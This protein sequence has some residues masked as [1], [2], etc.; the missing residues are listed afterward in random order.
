MGQSSSCTYSIGD[1][2]VCQLAASG[3]VDHSWQAS[4]TKTMFLCLFAL[5]IRRKKSRSWPDENKPSLRQGCRCWLASLSKPLLAICRKR[6]NWAKESQSNGI[7]WRT[8][9][10][11]NTGLKE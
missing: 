10:P 6:R 7:A 11:C 8:L 3:H 4:S 2:Q 5:F 1:A 9:A